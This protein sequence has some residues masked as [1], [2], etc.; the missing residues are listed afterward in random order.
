MN[1]CCCCLP[2]EIGNAYAVLSNPDKRRQYDVTGGEEPSSPGHAQAG[3]FDFHRGFEGDITPEDLF[4]MFFGGGF[5]S[6]KQSYCKQSLAHTIA[7]PHNHL[8]TQSLT[9]TITCSRNHSLTHSLTRL[10]TWFLAYTIICLHTHPLTN[11]PRTHVRSL[12]Q[13]LTI[14]HSQGH[15]HN[16]T[17][18][19]RSTKSNRNVCRISAISISV[20]SIS[21]NIGN[22]CSNRFA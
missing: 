22:P 18:T 17:H 6:C 21:V 8:L 15:S 1:T 11:H 5:P 14:T 13:S 10:L 2:P 9:H 4:N 19:N 16:H 20:I 3:G 12:T 7:N